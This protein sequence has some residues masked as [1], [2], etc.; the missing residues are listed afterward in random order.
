MNLFDI[1]YETSCP[2]YFEYTVTTF[3]MDQDCLPDYTINCI[4][5]Y[6][7]TSSFSSSFTSLLRLLEFQYERELHGP[8]L[9]LSRGSHPSKV[10]LKAD[11]SIQC[12]EKHV[13]EQ[14][15]KK[16]GILIT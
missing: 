16:I 6:Q 9:A 11:I 4:L 8:R 5:S 3:K 12:S 2:F 1:N 7:A 14:F 10:T 15:M 13:T